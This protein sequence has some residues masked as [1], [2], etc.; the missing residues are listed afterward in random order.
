MEAAVGRGMAILERG[1]FCR[2]AGEFW[3]GPCPSDLKGG[4]WG[5]VTETP[6]RA[7]PLGN[8]RWLL[9]AEEE[10]G[11]QGLVSKLLFSH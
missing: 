3:K 7:G 11:E 5:M 4:D 8:P 9:L 6:P 2:Q 1:C 10:S